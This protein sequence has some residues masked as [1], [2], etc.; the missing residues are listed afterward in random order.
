M[1][2]RSCSNMYVRFVRHNTNKREHEHTFIIIFIY[3]E[4][5]QTIRVQ[6]YFELNI[7]TSK[8]LTALNE[9][10]AIYQEKVRKCIRFFLFS[11][12]K[13]SFCS[14]I[15]VFYMHFIIFDEKTLLNDE[16]NV[17]KL[18]W[19]AKCIIFK[20]RDILLLWKN[21]AWRNLCS[22]SFKLIRW[23]VDPN[24]ACSELSTVGVNIT[25]ILEMHLGKSNKNIQ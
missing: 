17:V 4:C 2:I 18:L 22:V 14:C 6:P 24:K 21:A 11:K 23:S 7:L 20:C 9:S 25:Y 16:T 12:T 19:K 3:C 10:F 13:V 15:N 1:R 5:S 8:K